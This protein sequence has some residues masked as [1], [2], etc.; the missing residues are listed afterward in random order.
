MRHFQSAFHRGTHCYSPKQVALRFGQT[1]SPLFIA[2]L[3]ATRPLDVELIAFENSFS[4]LFI[5]A[6][7]ATKN[8]DVVMIIVFSFSPLF[9][10][11]LTATI[12][13]ECPVCRCSDF[14]SAFHRGT[15]CYSARASPRRFWLTFSPLFIAALTATF[16]LISTARSVGVFQ[17]AFHRGTHCY[18]TLLY[19]CTKCVRFQSAFHRGTHC[20]YIIPTSIPDVTSLSVRFSSRHSLLQL[21][22]RC[23][24]FR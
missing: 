5:A 6:L 23:P 24:V 16:W 8:G 11:A 19:E 4:P 9:I 15:H 17:S 3:T 22:H 1:F 20:Y 2:A 7:T 14:Q 12:G 21:Q 13:F 18:M 10:A